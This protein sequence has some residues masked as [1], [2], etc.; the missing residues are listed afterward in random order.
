[1]TRSAIVTAALLGLGTATPVAASE[2]AAPAAM[3]R[4][5]SVTHPQSRLTVRVPRTATYVGSDR[6]D[7]YG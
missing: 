1:M 3:V 6:F 4:G 5:H 7:L 2:T